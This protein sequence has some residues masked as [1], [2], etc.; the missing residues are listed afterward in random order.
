V[1]A[2]GVH[3]EEGVGDH[4]VCGEDIGKEEAA[5]ERAA[6]SEV[7]GVRGGGEERRC[8]GWVGRGECQVCG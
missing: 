6:E 3:G 1:A 5:V 2:L 8:V 7:A 4:G